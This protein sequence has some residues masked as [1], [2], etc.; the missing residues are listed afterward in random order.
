ME[1]LGDE[2]IAF[3][4]RMDGIGH[5]NGLGENAFKNVRDEEES[6]CVCEILEEFGVLIAQG[7][8]ADTNED[9][10]G[11]FLMEPFDNGSEVPEHLFA[12][13]MFEAVIA[14]EA[15]KHDAGFELSDLIDTR[16]AVGAGVTAFAHIEDFDAKLLG[17]NSG[18]I[19]SFRRSVAFS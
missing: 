10:K 13:G 17:E 12:R 9:H 3:V 2:P 7:R 16:E 4:V 11:A 6:V 5:V 8:A 1:A 14:P 19:L 18:I 15:E